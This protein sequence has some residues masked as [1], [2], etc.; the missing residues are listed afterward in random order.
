MKQRLRD[1]LYAAALAL[2]PT[3][4]L[5]AALGR[6]PGVRAW[7]V[8]PGEKQSVDVEGVCWVTINE[9]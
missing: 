1:R 9:D 6:R 7:F 4:A 5:Q 2:V 3:Y 8:A